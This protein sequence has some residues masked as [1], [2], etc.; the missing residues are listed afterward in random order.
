MTNFGEIHGFLH[1]SRIGLFGKNRSYLHLETYRLQEIFLSKTNQCSQ[2][3]NVLDTPPSNTY[4]FFSERYMC[5]FNSA[6]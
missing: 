2:G 6:A 3:H 4:G 5:F 1:V